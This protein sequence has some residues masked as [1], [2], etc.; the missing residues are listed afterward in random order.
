MAPARRM[1]CLFALTVVMTLQPAPVAADPVAV[2]DLSVNVTGSLGFTGGVTFEAGTSRAS[3]QARS[4][5][6]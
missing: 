5:D 2:G 3:S 1:C 4:P 6:S